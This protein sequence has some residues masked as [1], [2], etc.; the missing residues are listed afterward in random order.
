MWNRLKIGKNYIL[1]TEAEKFLLDSIGLC[2]KE[3]YHCSV[4]II[5]NALY[6]DNYTEMEFLITPPNKSIDTS[7]K[8]YVSY[9]PID[10][11]EGFSFK[12]TSIA[13][14]LENH[15]RKL[16]LDRESFLERKHQSSFTINTLRNKS[17]H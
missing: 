3:N 1:S 7:K 17:I 14:R 8:P 15:I 12:E 6:Y 5:A 10:K 2:H 11:Q 9:L 4:S 13:L 16:I